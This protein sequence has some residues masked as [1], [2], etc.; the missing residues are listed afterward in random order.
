MISFLAFVG[1]EICAASGKLVRV[2]VEEDA[3]AREGCVGLRAK[4]SVLVHG[5]GALEAAFHCARLAR[6]LAQHCADTYILA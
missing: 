2:A 3:D 1:V 5:G 4:V 6:Q